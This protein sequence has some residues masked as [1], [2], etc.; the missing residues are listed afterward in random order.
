[1]Q[2]LNLLLVLSID[3]VPYL[4]G[5]HPSDRSG[6]ALD[7]LDV[8]NLGFA[9][10]HRDLFVDDDQSWRQ[11]EVAWD[12]HA[13]ELVVGYEVTGLGVDR[14]LKGLGL[15]VE[16][17]LSHILVFVLCLF[18][19]DSI[20]PDLS[21]TVDPDQPRSHWYDIPTKIN[22]FLVVLDIWNELG[23]R[24][25]DAVFGKEGGDH[26]VG[27]AKHVLPLLGK[28]SQLVLE[29]ELVVFAVKIAI[30]VL[31]HEDVL[32]EGTIVKDM[33]HDRLDPQSLSS[34]HQ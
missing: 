19:R 28:D 21:A 20:L 25:E 23:F 17:A 10:N 15:L 13:V 18:D 6:E 8:P 32:L 1:M 16:E 24:V 11:G 34:C 14:Q 30:I 9:A 3:Q 31:E 22:F 5:D 29:L 27:R 33:A 2:T 12:V 7:D 26:K 4:I